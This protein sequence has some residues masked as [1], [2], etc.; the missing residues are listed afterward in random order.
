MWPCIHLHKIE[1][2]AVRVLT[3]LESSVCLPRAVA[4]DLLEG[5]SLLKQSQIDA[6]PR[7]CVSS[8]WLKKCGTIHIL[9]AISSL[10]SKNPLSYSWCVP[11]VTPS[12][13]SDGNY[14]TSR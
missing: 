11:N 3:F 6:F 8:V 14:A 10:G 7:E 13:G 5:I 9:H 2:F 12:T 4:I 1:I